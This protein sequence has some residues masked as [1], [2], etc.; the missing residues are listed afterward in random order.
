MK[1]SVRI[2]KWLW[3][4]R[5]FKTRS[6]ATE[7][8]RL[9]R[10]HMHGQPAKPA[11]PLHVGDQVAIEQTDLVRRLEVKELLEARIAAKLVPEYVIDLTPAEEIARAQAARIERRMATP[12]YD[13]GLGRPTK[14]QRRQMDTWLLQHDT[15]L[16][17][18]ALADDASDSAST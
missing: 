3:A 17:L 5:L 4:V 7:A 9:G 1:S 15:G 11:H 8:C 2:D 18:D 12:V 14:Q 13:P 6:L 10:V 16:H